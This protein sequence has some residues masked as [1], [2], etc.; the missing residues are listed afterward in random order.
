MPLE[1]LEHCEHV[2]LCARRVCKMLYNALGAW[3]AREKCLLERQHFLHSSNNTRIA[4]L[5]IVVDG[6]LIRLH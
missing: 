4:Q 3:H 5:H 6:A 2:G 1:H